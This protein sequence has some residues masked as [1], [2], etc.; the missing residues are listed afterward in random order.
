MLPREDVDAPSQGHTGW[1]HWQPDLM[2]GN[3]VHGRSLELTDL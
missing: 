1:A 3:L 2:G